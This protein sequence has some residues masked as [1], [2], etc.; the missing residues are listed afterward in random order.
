MVEFYGHW[1]IRGS[2]AYLPHFDGVIVRFEGKFDPN[3]IIGGT[4]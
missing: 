1:V 3:H 2:P 4:R